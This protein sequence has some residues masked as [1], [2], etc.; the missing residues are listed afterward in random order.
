[1][2]AQQWY[3]LCNEV[4]GKETKGMTSALMSSKKDATQQQNHGGECDP[5]GGSGLTGKILYSFGFVPGPFA[6]LA[7]SKAVLRAI[8]RL[9][10]P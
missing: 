1:M 9:S 8:L 5:S 3:R 10:S 7:S 4:S 6:H 2:S